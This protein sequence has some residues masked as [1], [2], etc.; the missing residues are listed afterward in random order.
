MSE[1]AFYIKKKEKKKKSYKKKGGRS[2]RHIYVFT[3]KFEFLN[4][5]ILNTIFYPRAAQTRLLGAASKTN[6]KK[7]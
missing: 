3:R 5:V 1:R 4:H 7:T 6:W 2:G